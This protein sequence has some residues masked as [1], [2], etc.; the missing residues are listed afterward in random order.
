MSEIEQLRAQNRKL[1]RAI[2]VLLIAGTITWA[3]SLTQGSSAGC[4][5]Y[6]ASSAD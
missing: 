5:G 3:A 1:K 4:P 2:L 6:A